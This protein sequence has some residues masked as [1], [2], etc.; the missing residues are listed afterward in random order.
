MGTK[1]QRFQCFK[2]M[3]CQLK[4]LPDIICMHLDLDGFSS[5]MRVNASLGTLRQIMRKE[6]GQISVDILIKCGGSGS[7][8]VTRHSVL[9]E[10]FVIGPSQFV[11]WREPS[12]ELSKR[13][14][15]LRGMSQI[16][17]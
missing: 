3:N 2:W 12:L 7:Q 8:S 15:R 17:L 11:D 6:R 14:Y 13:P 4:I 1:E 16:C 9:G 5:E 10:L